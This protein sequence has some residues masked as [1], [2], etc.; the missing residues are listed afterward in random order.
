MQ[1]V[2][3]EGHD[4]TPAALVR[5]PLWEVVQTPQNARCQMRSV[6]RLDLALPV[7]G[8]G[9]EVAA[10][11]NDT[12][13]RGEINNSCRSQLLAGD[14]VRE[15]RDMGVE[16]LGDAFVWTPAVPIEASLSRSSPV[17]ANNH[18]ARP[19][20]RALTSCNPNRRE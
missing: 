1:G 7:A 15:V 10:H 6:V 11:L 20:R 17:Q 2:R 16:T 12:P 13:Q 3:N 8:P 4:A 18:D 5:R 14:E 9:H 19:S